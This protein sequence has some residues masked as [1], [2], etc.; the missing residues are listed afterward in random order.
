MFLKS[1]VPLFLFK[2]IYIKNTLGLGTTVMVECLYAS[3][4]QSFYSLHQWLSKFMHVTMIF[5][6]PD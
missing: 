5:D 6:T 3:K 2:H 1:Y 4:H